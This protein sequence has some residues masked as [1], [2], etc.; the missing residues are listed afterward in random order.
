MAGALSLHCL[1][2]F[3]MEMIKKHHFAGKHAIMAFLSQKFMITRFSIAFED[4]LASSIA[5]QV[6]PPCLRQN[7][8]I[9]NQNQDGAWR[10]R[11][12]YIVCIFSAPFQVADDCFIADKRREDKLP[13]DFNL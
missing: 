3:V 10:W 11:W 7:S 8:N 12:V 6:M 2:L 1:H 5:P 13:V 4:L 9:A